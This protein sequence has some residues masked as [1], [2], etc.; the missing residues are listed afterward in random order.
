MWQHA[1]NMW[2]HAANIW[3]HAADIWQH[4]A[5]MWQHAA[6]IWQH[7]ANIWQHAA[8]VC[9]LDTQSR[10]LAYFCTHACAH[11]HVYAHARSCS[12]TRTHMHAHARSHAC[13]VTW[14]VSCVTKHA[15]VRKM[16]FARGRALTSMAAGGRRP[17]FA[18]ASTAHGARHAHTTWLLLSMP[19]HGCTFVVPAA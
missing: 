3:Q 19:W 8:H 9:V 13:T 10:Q 7:A 16:D 5:N 2:R 18:R 14:C 4:A 11:L 12:L 1:A 6:N 17:R 15:N